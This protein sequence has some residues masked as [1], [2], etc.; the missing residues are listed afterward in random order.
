[1]ALTDH[2]TMAGVSEAMQTAEEQEM[3]LLPS[4]ELDTESPFEL[5]C[6]TGR[7]RARQTC[8]R[9]LRIFRFAGAGAM[10]GY[11]INC[12]TL[13]MMLPRI[14]TNQRVTQRVCI[15]LWRCTRLVMLRV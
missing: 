9:R 2:D 12:G 10:Q 13:D 5:I 3:R 4:V 7:D 11:S 6:G 14:C 1:M 15:S 8:N